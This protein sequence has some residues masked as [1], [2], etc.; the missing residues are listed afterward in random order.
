M[1]VGSALSK[2]PPPPPKL[3]IRIEPNPR[4]SG[5]LYVFTD[6]GWNSTTRAEGLGWIVDDL[7]SLSQHS[8][9]AEHVSSP[10]MAEA[11]A[12]RSAINFALSR[13]IEAISIL[14]ETQNLIK[15]INRQEM[16]TEIFGILHDIYHSA[17]SF[18]SIKFSFIPRLINNNA[19]FVAKQTLWTL[20]SF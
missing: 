5:S 16:K 15:I 12:I 18:K 20:N 19:D 4:R 10:L 8:M 6:V 13:G 7:V 9:T 17:L 1:D 14:S 11:L 3:L 2:L